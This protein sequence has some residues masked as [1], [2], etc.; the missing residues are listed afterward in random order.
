M[1]LRTVII[2]F[3][4]IVV[5]ANI[6]ALNALPDA[7]VGLNLIVIGVL[8]GAGYFFWQQKMRK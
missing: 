6:I 2:L 1:N 3:A 7:L 5:I 8:A 4:V